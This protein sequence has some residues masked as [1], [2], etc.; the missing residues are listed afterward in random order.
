MFPKL[1][2]PL[3]GP[4]AGCTLTSLAPLPSH[5]TR[6]SSL[7]SLACPHRLLCTARRRQPAQRGPGATVSSLLGS[8]VAPPFAFVLHRIPSC[9]SQQLFQSSPLTPTTCSEPPSSSAGGL[10]VHL[11]RPSALSFHPSHGLMRCLAC[12]YFPIYLLSHNSFFL[13][14]PY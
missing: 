6:A 3:P 7:P 10:A 9:F 12:G 2:P 1:L 5:H 14:S 4:M 8:Y 13:Q 11:Q